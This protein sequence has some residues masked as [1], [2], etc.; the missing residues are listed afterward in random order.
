MSPL[1][2]TGLK[3]HQFFTVAVGASIGVG[4]IPLY[5][6][7]LTNAGSLGVAVAFLLGALLMVFVAKG[8]IAVASRLSESGGETMYA[9][10]ILGKKIGF[11][12][13]WFLAFT[14]LAVCVFEALSIAL[15][16]AE[17]LP[18]LSGSVLYSI[19]GHD[20]RV[21]TLAISIISTAFMMFLHVRGIQTAAIFQDILTF[22][23]LAF[24][25]IFII[26]GLSTGVVG[27]L[28][29]MFVY[30][31]S[32]W[33]LGG[34]VSV[35]AAAPLLISGF[36]FSV[37]IIGDRAD[38][39]GVASVAKSLFIAIL[40]VGIFYVGLFVAAAMSLPRE[41]L[42]SA[43][44]PVAAAF[45]EVFGSERFGDIIFL[46]AIL[47]LFTTWNAVLLGLNKI[48]AVLS[49][50]GDIPKIFSSKSNQHDTYQA[51]IQIV[52][53]LTIVGV[54]GGQGM[55]TLIIGSASV[56]MTAAYC[57]VMVCAITLCRWSGEKCS[58]SL[59]VSFC[60]AFALFLIAVTEPFF[61]NPTIHL[62]ITWSGILVWC[63]LGVILWLSSRFSEHATL[64][65]GSV[66]DHLVGKKTL[67]I[68][69]SEIVSKGNKV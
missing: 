46:V 52:S 10:T 3:P 66:S 65:A 64:N 8:Y 54:L 13:G 42:I 33:R 49:I 14:Y 4:W 30:Q 58:I 9:Y 23:L 24:S 15:F 69:K 26:L 22:L 37:Q 40:A 51:S 41:V 17:L 36:N 38:G 50:N 1:N 57:V 67:Y 20:V 6:A 39:V 34:M 12:T 27:N 5:G 32:G 2:K 68:G 31:E 47:G 56:T 11:F 60:I 28:N 29:P 59:C 43:D 61:V 62:P 55:L 63:G 7:W 19:L 35:F 18:N 25:L 44:L 16:S 53:L 45:V 48:L 21:G